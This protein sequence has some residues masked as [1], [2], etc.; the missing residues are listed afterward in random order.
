MNVL[1]ESGALAL[2]LLLSQSTSGQDT[3]CFSR[4]RNGKDNFV[5]DTD[6]SVKDGATFLSAPKLERTRD[7]VAACCKN[8]RC[9]VALMEKGTEEDDVKSCFL[10]DCLY[11]Q[12][13]V[14]RF[15]RKQGYTNHVS[16]KLYEHIAVQPVPNSSDSPPVAEAGPDLVVQPRESVTLNGVQ[17]RDDKE[18]TEFKWEMLTHYPFAVIEKTNF[19]DQIIVSNLTSG[20]YKF[21][22][23]VK[24]AKDQTDSTTI[25]IL[26]LTPEQSENHCMVPM[27][28]GPCRGAFPRWHFNAASGSCEEFTF[29]GCRGNLNNY[30]NKDEC[31]KACADIGKSTRLLPPVT[32]EG[33]QCG[34]PCSIEQFTCDNGC[35]L[36]PGLEC[37]DTPQCSDKSDENNCA[38]LEN[39]FRVLTQIPVDENKVRCTE[40]P[41][42]GTCRDSQTKW[43]YDPMS[44]VCNS[45]NYGGCEGN[46][47][48]FDSEASCQKICKGVQSTDVF[49]RKVDPEKREGDEND[50][51]TIAIAI[52]LGVGILILLGVLGYCLLKKKKS[53]QHVPIS[54]A[55]FSTLDDRDYPVYNNTT[56]PY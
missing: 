38:D 18:I 12:K 1:I 15:V 37:D 3:D 4:F 43:Y 56:K 14:C 52:V 6:E 21:Q 55:A 46:E 10:F 11:K 30:L 47:N 26:V 25:T 44:Q 2:L 13:Y 34:G 54:N 35:C 50:I 28:T 20:K 27:K 24:D 9:N 53:A 49:A 39:K 22:L 42:T 33:E 41:D 17:S 36:S 32:S 5:L 19:K 45:F 48:R 8:P 23:T 40:H 31:I 7:C 16:D 29:G 51:G